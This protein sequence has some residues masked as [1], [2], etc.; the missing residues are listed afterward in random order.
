MPYIDNDWLD[1]IGSELDKAYFTE[2]MF[3]LDGEYSSQKIYPERKDLFNAYEYCS[4]SDI[5][6]MILGQDPYHGLG[7]AHGLS[8]SVQRGVKIPPSL[9][10][11]FKELNSDLNLV[12]PKHGCLETWA[13]QGVFL[14]N[15]ILS[16]RES[17]PLSHAGR[18]WE[19]FTDASIKAVNSIDRPV[20]ILLWGKHAMCKSKYLDNPRHLVLTAPHP[21]PLSA[22]RGFFGCAHFSRANE[23]L[24]ANG[25]KPIDFS[26]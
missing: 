9:K 17:A 26:L 15:S 11:I 14:L 19:K 12:I 23:Y 25:V 13:K 4:A 21:S 18:G 2:L 20:V 24:I 7:Q 1:Y 8:F 6:I 3:F 16:V 22:Y 5:K 10:N